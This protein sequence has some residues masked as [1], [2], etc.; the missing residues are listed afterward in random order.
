MFADGSREEAL[1]D[2]AI[3]IPDLAARKAFLDAECGDDTTIRTALEDL[4]AFHDTADDLLARPVLV[5]P[6]DEFEEHP[7]AVVGRYRIVER[8][9]EGGFGTVYRALQIEP[10]QR[11]VALKVVKPGLGSREVIA[12]FE[13]ERQS[14]ALMSHPNIATVFDGGTTPSGRPYFAMELVHGRPLDEFCDVARLSISERLR[15]FV[16]VCRAVQHAHHKGIVHRDLKPSNILVAIDDERPVPK[17]IDFGLA[18]AVDPSAWTSLTGD[19][20]GLLGT[21]EY[22]SP[23]QVT[24]G[25]EVDTRADVYA[26]GGVLY[27][28]LAGVSPLDLSA[29]PGPG[30]HEVC[31]AISESQPLT[32]SQRAGRLASLAGIAATR[33]LKPDQLPAVLRGDLDWIVMKALEKEPSRRFE[34]ASELALDI[35]SYLDHRPVSAGPPSPAYLARKFVRR[36]RIAVIAGVLIASALSLGGA[37]SLAGFLRARHEWRNAEHLRVTAETDRASAIAERDNARQVS[38]LLYEMVGATNP[39]S[40]RSATSTVLALLDNFADSLDGRLATQPD[41]EAMVRRAVGRSY[42][43]LGNMDKAGPHLER[44]LGLRSQLH[45]EAHPLTAQSRVDFALYLL[46]VSRLE[47][48]ERSVRQALPVLEALDPTEDMAWGLYALA[49]VRDEFGDTAEGNRFAEQAWSVARRVH[50]SDHPATLHMQA[51]VAR[52]HENLEEG[53]RLARDALER[54]RKTRPEQHVSVTVLKRN[55]AAVL[56]ARSQFAEAERLAREALDTDR[57]LLGP[58]SSHAVQ[59]LLALGEALSG[60]GRL[61]EAELAARQAATMAEHVTVERDLLRARAYRLLATMLDPE[62]S[63][64]GADSELLARAIET[65]RSVVGDHPEVGRLL[66]RRGQALLSAGSHREAIQCLRDALTILRGDMKYIDE[67]GLAHYLLGEAL[68]DV[69]EVEEAIVHLRDAAAICREGDGKLAFIY[70]F[71]GQLLFETGG[72]S[73]L[74][75]HVDDLKQIAKRTGHPFAVRSEPIAEGYLQMAQGKFAEA[76]ATLRA[77]LDSLWGN[78][79]ALRIRMRVNL[80]RSQCLVRLG[81]FDEAED[82]LQQIDR[83]VRK[84]PA[85]AP[86]DSLRL[87]EAMIFL[88]ESWDKPEQVARWRTQVK[89]GSSQPGSGGSRKAE[90]DSEPSSSSSLDPRSQPAS[91]HSDLAP[92]PGTPTVKP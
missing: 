37:L 68:R 65:N 81:R 10:I 90:V 22:M 92:E 74:K 6:P 80:A 86:H 9:A 85:F 79:A 83:R 15:L 70:L 77:T 28:L 14:L 30:I 21:P 32:P 75:Q 40:G 24:R 38:E 2:A 12:R 78:P 41:V 60:A 46:Q 29:L 25:S 19:L 27:K 35:E 26:L 67:L 84:F 62:V 91:L 13:A 54:L 45:G 55:L 43:G 8:I 63:G 17:V 5:R 34:T 88:Y 42:W 52:R 36:H 1:F 16:Q 53:E 20:W 48:A 57:Q 82:I 64:A 76:E 66:R 44:A 11:E 49:R 47:D 18:K 33:D 71:L 50:G 73:E 59:D 4:L 58:E 89:T 69:G 51:Y 56:T 72:E 31:R 7:G 3:Q 61:G 87:A 39:E 23:E